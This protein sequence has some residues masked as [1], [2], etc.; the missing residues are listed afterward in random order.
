MNCSKI[1]LD[2][3][4]CLCNVLGHIKNDYIYYDAIHNNLLVIINKIEDVILF[5]YKVENEDNKDKIENDS[6]LFELFY[7]LFTMETNTTFYDIF[8]K[9]FIKFLKRLKNYSINIQESHFK[10]Y[11]QYYS[12][13][14]EYLILEKKLDYIGVE[15]DLYATINLSKVISSLFSLFEKFNLKNDKIKNEEILQI[16]FQFNHTIF[17]LSKGNYSYIYFSKIFIETFQQIIKNPISKEDINS[18]AQ[19]IL[20]K[21]IE[22]SKIKDEIGANIDNIEE[23][24]YVETLI[25]CLK[26][27]CK[28]L[29]IKENCEL[30][31]Y[32]TKLNLVKCLI[33][34]SFWDNPKIVNYTCKIFSNFLK[35]SIEIPNFSL[36]KE[37]EK[38]I[39]FIYLRH[40]STYYNYLIDEFDNQENENENNE[41]N[42]NVI[43]YSEKDQRIKLTVLEIIGRHF[44]DLISQDYFLGIIFISCDLMK[45]R[46]KVINEIFSSIGNYFKLKN[47]M[48]VYL[49]KIFK[50]T[51]QITLSK[52]FHFVKEI[53]QDENNIISKLDNESDK[54]EIIQ[55]KI[56]EGK[57]KDLYKFICSEFNLEIFDRKK[58]IKEV[59]ENIIENYKLIAKEI[60]ILIRYSNYVNI[61]I[62]YETLGENYILSKLILEEY[63]KTF[64]FRGLDII[65]A[66]EL[67]VYTFNVTGEQFH[68]YN[69]IEQF[70]SKYYLDNQNLT[71]EN[72]FYFISKDEVFTLAYSIM[73]LNTD[74]HNPNISTHMTPEEFIKSNLAS[75]YF[76]EF[77]LEYFN[78]IYQRILKTP[79]R[80]AK[81]R[82]KNYIQ[83]EEIY[84]DMKSLIL[85]TK[86]DKRI[87]DLNLFN[88]LNKSEFLNYKNFPSLNLL[89]NIYFDGNNEQN[90]NLLSQALFVLY[91]DLFGFILNLHYSFFGENDESLINILETI[92][93]IAVKI[94][95][96]DYINKLITTISS[97]LNTTKSSS[98]YNIFFRISMKFN[99]DFH[100][101]LE[102]FYQAI[103]DVL[104]HK[105]KE[106]NNPLR[107][108]YTK[109]INDIIYKTFNVITLKKREK[110]ENSGLF[111][112]FFSG[113][114]QEKEINFD[115]FRNKIYKRMGL[116]EIKKGENKKEQLMDLDQI[117]DLIKSQDEEFI[118]F[119]TFSASKIIE[120]Q[121]KNELYISIIFLKEMLKNISQKSFIKI[122]PNLY[123]IFKSR[124]EFKKE[125]EDNLFDMLYINYFLHQII[126]QYFT[127]IENEEYEQL[128]EN[129]SDIDN[130]EILYIILENNDSL[131]KNANQN[132]KIINDKIFQYLIELIYK[133]LFKLK[134]S[135]KTDISI[136]LARFIKTIEFFS[137][138]L[139]SIKDINSIKIE[140]IQIIK[141]IIKLM[142]DLQITEVLLNNNFGNNQIFI[143]IKLLADKIMIVLSEIDDEN[144][145]LYIYLS[146]F[147]LKI[148][149]VENEEIQKKF[150]NCLFY[151]FEKKK[152]PLVRYTQIN[153]LIL[154][155]YP[156]FM[157]LKKKYDKFFED[158]FQFFFIL[159]SN[160]DLKTNQKEIE[161]LW[162]SFCRK[163]LISFVDTNKNNFDNCLPIIKKNYDVVHKIVKFLNEGNND[164]S[165]WESNKNSIKLYFPQIVDE[166]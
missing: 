20:N 151:L 134:I 132:Q 41:N 136:S 159:F 90:L 60:S 3:R 39:D 103:E 63:A 87:T 161:K 135:I 91:D 31:N 89:N 127:S 123:N 24:Y 15:S 66:Y 38:C 144:W 133:L 76:K 112:F 130:A 10:T 5:L 125:N 45:I 11:H 65:S 6:K 119:I 117:F 68:I 79:L 111:N 165:W 140:S 137:N 14:Y 164:I 95:Q 81:P 29:K 113:S 92:C 94:K 64:E 46:F 52:I 160:E 108:E 72:N 156:A 122:W 129:Y 114:S 9:L 8:F 143:F 157:S 51:Y 146:Q 67:Y 138:I 149:L 56:N 154:N 85:Y 124:M 120:F 106:E 7:I 33:Q 59:P 1:F 75:N 50:I 54:W 4:D 82:I 96:K 28:F 110:N 155:W 109:S 163:Y 77:P 27:S 153:E 126:S 78:E 70:S 142:F 17:L 26:L 25:I 152:I 61:S 43:I 40:F 13:I 116:E 48:Y 16:F 2:F 162:N 69:F 105:L 57:F 147:C 19:I 145:D 49:K 12:Q 158:I 104:I 166:K 97:F 58:Q 148:S 30:L 98:I 34:L 23:S 42:Q 44:N 37:I 62:L 128:L 84:R 131:I 150:F 36:R 93:N 22:I 86:K 47:D 101:N 139:K 100:N 71:K 80:T 88:A 83:C 107:E 35:I 74:L 73:I 99:K 32:N 18:L 115:D 121:N 102:V 141:D 53:K 21:I 118:F 55:K